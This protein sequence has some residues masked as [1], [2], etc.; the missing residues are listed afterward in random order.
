MTSRVLKKE[1]N[2]NVK[3]HGKRKRTIE[4]PGIR[5]TELGIEERT[6][7]KAWNPGTQPGLNEVKESGMKEIIPV[8]ESD[9][10]GK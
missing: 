6:P 5:G 9:I 2:S 8:H 1:R 7:G 10:P 4:S 3:T